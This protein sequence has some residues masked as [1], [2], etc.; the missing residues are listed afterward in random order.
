MTVSVII[1]VKN[2]KLLLRRTLKNV[3]A[4]TL[5]PTEVIVVDD[6]SDESLEELKWEFKDK[7]IFVTSDGRG[8][9]AARN[10]GFRKST[11]KYIQFF[12]SDDLMSLD[13]LETQVAILEKSGRG[14]TYCTY[15]KA[16][17]TE[18]GEWVQQDDFMYYYPIPGK[19]RYDQQVLRGAN[20]ITQACL[21][22]REL[23]LH[24]GP[25]REDLMPHEDL[26]FMF[27]VGRYETSPVHSNQPFVL[28]RQHKNQITDKE[29]STEKRDR[30]ALKAHTILLSMMLSSGNYSYMDF[31]YIKS[32]IYHD[33]MLLKIKSKEATF[34]DKCFYYLYQIQKKIY[35]KLNSTLWAKYNAVST[36]KKIFAH[37]I[38]KLDY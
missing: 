23:L 4:Q 31:K 10:T 32:S 28:Y 20:M 13:K 34:A 14:M 36:D 24:I 18:S 6:H 21:F 35:R 25:W 16:F 29:I 3:L 33:C 38:S 11:G 7:V 17:E 30:D 19:L 12:D 1:P 9:G 5:T 8:P 26:D 27:R 37:Y 2:R 15:V 22:T